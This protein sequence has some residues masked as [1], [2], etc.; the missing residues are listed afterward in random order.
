MRRRGLTIRAVVDRERPRMILGLEHLEKRTAAA[1]ISSGSTLVVPESSFARG[2]E[3]VLINGQ[4]AAQ[5]SEGTCT[6]PTLR[7]LDN[8]VACDVSRTAVHQ[9]SKHDSTRY[10]LRS[11]VA[12]TSKPLVVEPMPDRLTNQ[13]NSTSTNV[14]N[15]APML[16]TRGRFRGGTSSADSFDDYGKLRVPN[17]VTF[18]ISRDG[19][20]LKNL[21]MRFY[22][23]EYWHYDYDSAMEPRL[24]HFHESGTPELT[25]ARTRA[26]QAFTFDYVDDSART[27]TT[28]LKLRWNAAAKRFSAVINAYTDNGTTTSYSA[29]NVLGRNVRRVSIATQE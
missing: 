10:C 17:G 6:S 22:A 9:G 15:R 1:A 23:I 3:I 5:P 11:V 19:R 24:I 20:T 27:W 25:L 13:P 7:P 14:V 28:E 16:W 8:E 2:S 18:S 12:A 4:N 21:S 29:T 26:W